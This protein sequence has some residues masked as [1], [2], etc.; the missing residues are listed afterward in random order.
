MLLWNKIGS[1]PVEKWTGKKVNLEQR[2]I[3]KMT[4]LADQITVF[5]LRMNVILQSI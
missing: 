3:N 2:A 5:N 4:D 1:S